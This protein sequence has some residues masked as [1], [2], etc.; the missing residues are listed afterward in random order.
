MYHYEIKPIIII[1]IIMSNADMFWSNMDNFQACTYCDP[2]DYDK[3][4][5]LIP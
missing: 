5:I 2:Y 1:I 4:I 3:R